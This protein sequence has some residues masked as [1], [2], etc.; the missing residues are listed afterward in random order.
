MHVPVLRDEVLARL[1]LESGNSAIDCTFG[2]GGYTRMLLNA[3]AP[4]GRVLAVDAD[5]DAIARGSSMDWTPEE[6]ERLTLTHGNFSDI[7]RIARSS[8]FVAP[9][10]IVADLGVSSFQ[11]NVSDRGFSFAHG[12]PLDMRFDPQSGLP[13]AA[14]IVREASVDELARVL[15]TYGEEPN[16]RRIA[17]EIV[18]VRARH[19]IARTEELADIVASVVRRRTRIHPATRTF[20]ALRIA[21]NAELDA[22]ERGLAAMLDLVAPGGRIAIVSFHSLEDR[23]V[24]RAFRR[25]KD[26]HRGTLVTRK[27]V[28]PSRSEVLANPRSRS[29]KLRVFARRGEPLLGKQIP[30]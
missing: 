7:G 21:V 25:A 27:P 11:L 30:V 17:E 26:D 29:A 28:T 8:G 19:T 6:R 13:T 23:I 5:P 2:G 9:Q 4:D 20:Q 18:R 24:K 16:A 22:L 1:A 10:G 14:D 15:R 3:V 12:G